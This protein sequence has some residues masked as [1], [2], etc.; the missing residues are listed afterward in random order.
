MEVG[1]HSPWV[2]HHLAAQGC[3]TIVA[4][5]R[6]LRAIYEN[7][8][9]CDK[10]DARMIARLTRFDPELLCPVEHIS[11]DALAD[12]MDLGCRD[13]LVDHRK[14]LIQ[15]VRSSVKSLGFR[16]D[17]CSAPVFARTVRDHFSDQPYLLEMVEPMLAAIEKMT[18]GIRQL[19]REIEK[20]GTEKYKICQ[21]FREVH[22][23]GPLTSLAFTL[24]IEDPGR[25]EK[26]RDV[27][28]YLGM[29]PKRDQSGDTDRNLGISKTGTNTCAN[30]WCNVLSTCSGRMGRTATCGA[31]GKSWRR[32]VAKRR[33]KKPS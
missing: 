9:K 32:A 10:L 23:V 28:A 12:R 17:S 25:I 7:E 19:D 13:R 30:C 29:V 11:G 15:S 27:G 21:T 8:R 33:R 3:E 4:N 18:E 31:S 20:L 26:T 5:A 16:I 6:K 1:T 2:S 22:G 24:A 14:S